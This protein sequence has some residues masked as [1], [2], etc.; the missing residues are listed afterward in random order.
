MTYDNETRHP[1][2]DKLAQAVENPSERVI[3]HMIT[4]F[5]VVAV[6]ILS[7]LLVFAMG[8]FVNWQINHGAWSVDARTFVVSMWVMLQL[9][10]LPAVFIWR[11][12]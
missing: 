2:F 8:V 9:L 7:A 5:M 12:E 10:F 1:L 6:L 3:F 4:A 11:S